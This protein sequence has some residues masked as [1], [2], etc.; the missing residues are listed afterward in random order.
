MGAGSV[1]M[2]TDEVRLLWLLV[3]NVYVSVRN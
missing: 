2:R 3:S 1:V